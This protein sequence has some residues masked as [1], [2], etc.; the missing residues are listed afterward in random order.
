MKSPKKITETIRSRA[1]TVM[2]ETGPRVAG[3]SS[4]R[5]RS[6]RHPISGR[7]RGRLASR[8]DRANLAER[9]ARERER[10]EHALA[11]VPV[12]LDVEGL[13]IGP[14]P[15]FGTGAGRDR[16]SSP[17]SDSA[18]GTSAPEL[19]PYELESLACPICSG[20]RI[21]CDEV[22]Q[23]GALRLAECLRC[24]HLWTD[25]A[26][27]RWAGVGAKMKRVV[28]PAAARPV[29]QGVVAR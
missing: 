27:G 19:M 25:R 18:I 8:R 7:S 16:I 28:R 21:V 26:P 22:F 10:V 24:E 9:N 11:S 4:Q 20:T 5:A 23:L 29:S 3:S 13:L 1:A 12:P 15:S 2:T 6:L 14:N 17:R